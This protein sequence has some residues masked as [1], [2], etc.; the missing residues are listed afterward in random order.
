MVEVLD[1]TGFKEKVF[2]FDGANEWNFKGEKPALIDL[3]ADWCAPCKQ[4]EPIIEEISN[5]RE[6]IDVYKVDVEAAPEIA[7]LFGVSG[8]PTFVFIPL[9]GKPALASGAIAKASFEE[10]IDS[11]MFGEGEQDAAV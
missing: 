4:T 9:D 6:G 1:T 8:I 10:A 11:Y 5:E 3:Y 7:Q 2:D